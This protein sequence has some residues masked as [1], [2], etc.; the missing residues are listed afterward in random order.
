MIVANQG[1]MWKISAE[2]IAMLT[3]LLSQQKIILCDVYDNPV[4]VEI[5]PLLQACTDRYT[6]VMRC[7]LNEQTAGWSNR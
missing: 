5:Q 7:W 6:T 4:E 3:T 2:F 1:G